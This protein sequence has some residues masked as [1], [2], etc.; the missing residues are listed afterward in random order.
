V[1]RP[2]PALRATERVSL[3]RYRAEVGFMRRLRL[4]GLPSFW[5]ASVCA[6]GWRTL[7]IQSRRE[8]ATRSS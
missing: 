3:E 1:T 5:H 7:L 6:Q 4:A 8:L 2:I